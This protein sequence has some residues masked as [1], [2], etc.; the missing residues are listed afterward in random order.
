MEW[1]RRLFDSPLYFELYE[2][3][4]VARAREQ[5]PQIL[6]LL[7][8][9]PPARILDVPCGYGRHAVELAARGFAVTGVDISDVQLARARQRADQ[10]GVAVTWV[11]Q[12]VRTLALAAEFDAAI[13]MFLSFGYF[14]TDEENFAMLA[15]I[16]RALRPGGRFV[17]DYWNREYEIRT[18]DQYQVDRTGDVFEVEEWEFDHLRGRLNWTNHVFFPDGR[19]QSWFHSIRAYTVAEVVAMLDRAGFQL[20]GVYGG[21]DGQPYSL[22]AEAAV[23]VATRR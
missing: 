19:R 16:A 10:A 22:D 18:F 2:P 6:S 1:W 5:V 21:L 20:D 14:D 7:R 13:C 23:F 9:Q 15:G 8:L 17:L 4:D 12:D 3:Q 11:R